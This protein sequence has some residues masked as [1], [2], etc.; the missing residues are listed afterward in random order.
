MA[1]S[2]VEYRDIGPLGFPGYEVG[3]DGSV[4]T[5]R[6]GERKQLRPATNS[7]STVR[8][9]VLQSAAGS[10]TRAVARLVL[11]AFGRP[12]PDGKK[13]EPKYLDGDPANCSLPNLDWQPRRQRPRK[14]Q[15]PATAAN[16]DL[17]AALK[18]AIQLRRAELDL[19][20]VECAQRAGMTREL[21][22]RA[23]FGLIS[24]S[25]ETLLRVCVALD[26]TPNDLLPKD[27]RARI[28]AEPPPK[29]DP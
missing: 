29:A 6:A 23:E 20:Q 21:W 9:V 22:H 18:Q 5:S 27:W 4:W 7:G 17:R 16:F 10:K 1:E 13:S 26:C 11:T 19:R 14:P 3:D 2:A 25:V 24:L 12:A 15:R 28:R 8:Q